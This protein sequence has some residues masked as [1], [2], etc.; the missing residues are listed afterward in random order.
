MRLSGRCASLA[1]IIILL[2]SIVSTVHAQ[3]C[4]TEYVIVEGDSLSQIAARAYGKGSKWT[5]IFYANQDRLGSNATLISPG[6]SIRIPCINSKDRK[7]LPQSA[8]KKATTKK[9]KNF[10]ISRIVQKVELLTA[11]G[12]EP[13]T[14]RALPGG[15]IVTDIVSRSLDLIKK[16]AEGDF[17]YKI[18]WVNDWA[19]HLDPLL[20]N[21]AFDAGFPWTKPNCENFGELDKDT[22]FRCRNFFFSDPVYEIFT[23]L[24]TKKD[25]DLAFDRDDDIVGRTLCQ[26]YGYS[27]SVLDQDGRNWIKDN[28]I[29]LMRP[30]TPE[31]CFRLLNEGVIDAVVTSDLTGKAVISALGITDSVKIIERPVS[32]GTLNVIVPKTHPQ[33][34]TLLYYVNSALKKLKETGEYDKIARTHL[35]R[36]WDSVQGTQMSH[37]SAPAS[38]KANAETGSDAPA[39]TG[40]IPSP[41]TPPADEGAKKPASPGKAQDD[42]DKESTQ[43]ATGKKE[44]PK[45]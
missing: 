5:V 1:S 15:G 11:D 9:P 10:A 32:I 6:V 38:D 41:T 17:D 25:S 35:S 12:Y 26:P 37:D 3:T 27:T 30:Q 39:S 29:V 19:A 14:G 43:A 13:F 7:G 36:F 40:A 2:S 31:D 16:E 18:S 4:G 28:Q 42:S 21:R 24:V 33:A 8:T 45:P 44:A 34:R 20:I 23:V 22:Q